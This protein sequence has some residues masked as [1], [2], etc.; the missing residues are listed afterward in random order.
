M[1]SVARRGAVRRALARGVRA[2]LE[3]EVEVLWPE[4]DAPRLVDRQRLRAQPL[5]HEHPEAVPVAHE[6][7]RLRRDGERLL[8]ERHVGTG[9]LV[10]HELRRGGEGLDAV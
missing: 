4:L 9:Q 6:A 2:Q 5:E 8:A 1:P 10:A 3:G 7:A